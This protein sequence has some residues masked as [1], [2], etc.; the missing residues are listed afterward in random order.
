MTYTLSIT[1]WHDGAERYWCACWGDPDEGCKTGSGDSEA[2]AI[3][4]LVDMTES[5]GIRSG[6]GRVS[7]RYG[8][9]VR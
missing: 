6:P 3:R 5:D 1:T 9:P 4:N 8:E 7:D 2:E